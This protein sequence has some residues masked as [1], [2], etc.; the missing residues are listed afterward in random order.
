MTG[1]Y[2]IALGSNRRGRAGSPADQLRKALTEINGVLRVSPIVASAPVG[3]SI[4]RFANAVALV[5]SGLTPPAMLA[6]L[7][8]IE[9][10]LGRR[11]GRR[12]GARP[13]DLDLIGWSS[14]TWQ[15]PTLTIPHPRFRERAFVLGPLL[16]IA[17]DWHDPVT[18]RTVRQLLAR[19]TAPRPMPS[20]GCAGASR[21]ALL[22]RVR[23][24][25][26]RASDF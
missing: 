16:A 20:C 18:G 11:R 24:S 5:E 19:L 12:W 7:K 4:R 26:G 22:V 21:S 9:R 25:V 13:I 6:H 10:R 14:G 2:L 23:S 17:P 8:T 15:S 1:W 3:P